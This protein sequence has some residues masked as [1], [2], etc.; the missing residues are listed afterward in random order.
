[1]KAVKKVDGR[2]LQRAKVVL[3]FM[4]DGWRSGLPSRA[5]AEAM[6]RAAL[7]SPYMSYLAQYDGIRR[8]EI[9]GA[10]N[11]PASVGTRA[12]DPR[13]FLPEVQLIQEKEVTDALERQMD[14]TPRP[15]GEDSIFFAIISC[16]TQPVLA[17]HQ[18]SG[19]FHLALAHGD[20]RY[21]YAMI[22]NYAGNTVENIWGDLA[23]AFTHEL[24]EACTDP[25]GVN[26]YRL[27]PSP[28]P[29]D[30]GEN[31]LCDY[32]PKTQ[33]PLPALPRPVGLEGYWSNVHDR[34]VTPT[35]YSLRA[36]LGQQT[37]TSVPDVG[38]SLGSTTVRDAVRA[39][40]S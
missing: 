25:G 23:V 2:V 13:K 28:E 29:K 10:F 40:C 22:L 6:F 35:G 19:G 30:P 36:A 34:W 39:R 9:V 17:N 33:V 1:M 16:G 4:G 24:V 18:D 38:A 7:A 15:A 12:P 14:L 31:E 21:E 32:A 3:V 8:A 5:D 11:G 26:G 27:T 37:S 20:R